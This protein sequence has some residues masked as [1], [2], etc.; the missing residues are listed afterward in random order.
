MPATTPKPPGEPTESGIP[1]NIQVLMEA[2]KGE[3]GY[4][5]VYTRLDCL[6][7]D[8][9]GNIDVISTM[10]PCSGDEQIEDAGL[11]LFWKRG[12]PGLLLYNMTSS[13]TIMI[14]DDTSCGPGEQIRL[15][16]DQIDDTKA[17]EFQGRKFIVGLSINGYDLHEYFIPEDEE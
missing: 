10:I 5:Q 15:E 2:S 11:Y 7:D 14:N 9:R 16:F 6:L 1:A 8:E 4:S 3:G 12:E 13:E 17:L